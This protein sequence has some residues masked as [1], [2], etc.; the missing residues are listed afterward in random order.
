MP[1]ASTNFGDHAAA[2]SAARLRQSVGWFLLWTVIFGLSYTQAPLYFSNQNQYFLHGLAR[3]G[4]GFLDDDWLASTRDPTWTFSSMVALVAGWLDPRVF[5]LL[6]LLLLGAYFCSLM[7]VAGRLHPGASRPALV[8][9]ATL[10]VVVHAGIVRLASARLT[11]VDYP[12][13]LQAGVA[14]QYLLGFGLQPSACGVFLLVSVRAFVADRPWQAATWACVAAILHAT[15]LLAAGLLVL[16]YMVSYF[17]DGRPRQALSLG[18]WSL[19]LVAPV[20]AYSLAQF[21]PS[22]PESFAEAQHILAHVRVPHHA[23]P[24]R[25]FDIIALGQ[26]LWIVAAIALVWG[27]RLFLITVIV[28]AA[29]LL[30]TGL[31][32]ITGSDALAL[33]FPWRTSAL[34]MPL[35][36]TI[37]LARLVILG[38]P[39]LRLRS[40]RMVQACCGAA[41]ALCVAG[42][43]AISALGWGYHTSPDETP[44]LEFVKAHKQRGDVYLL[45]VEI[46][47]TGAGPRGS[48][49]RNKNFTPAPRR[50]GGGPHISV[51]LQSFRLS[52]GAPIY[53]DFKS[54]PYQD[55]EVIEWRDRLVWNEQIF[56]KSDWDDPGLLQQLRHR[57]ITHVVVPA[58][59]PLRGAAPQMIFGDT[60]YR[61]YRLQP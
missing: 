56:E 61:L 13:F 2:P 24:E 30:L 17:R 43:I 10:L 46:P 23:D 12:W 19:L 6:Y 47:K 11:G 58:A 41:L 42:G 31:Q 35:A 4:Y 28:F 53:V 57:R 51:D 8:V 55:R 45:P 21:G 9:I 32:L 26:V 54:I 34:L 60:A 50:G 39:W 18:L 36:T 33:L 44:L 1:A 7:G 22:D 49:S 37:I 59:R 15:Y 52:T 29:S 3:A 27:T 40:V 16:S 38:D 14:G 25:W 5:Y 48:A 20:V